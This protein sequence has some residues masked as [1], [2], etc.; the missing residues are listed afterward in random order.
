MSSYQPSDLV[1]NPVAIAQEP[2]G[3]IVAFT[4]FRPTGRDNGWVLD[5]LRRVPGSVPG[6]V[7]SCLVEAAFGLRSLGAS[8]LSLGLAPLAGLDPIAGERVNLESALVGRN[9][10]LPLHVDVLNALVDPHDL[11]GERNAE[12]E[13][14]KPQKPA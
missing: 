9:H 6:A 4:T 8:T 2:D 5:L 11:L 14:G 10:L 13:S 1:T 12:G 3:R 7:E